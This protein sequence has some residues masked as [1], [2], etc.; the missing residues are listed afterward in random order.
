MA[1]TTIEYGLF[2]QFRAQEAANGY[3]MQAC[4]LAQLDPPKLIQLARRESV[5]DLAKA[6]Q[7]GQNTLIYAVLRKPE[8]PAE[9]RIPMQGYYAG[10]VSEEA[11]QAWMDLR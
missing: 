4:V 2:R 1:I 7:I 8:R 9:F 6:G 11:A 5:L 3:A 10:S